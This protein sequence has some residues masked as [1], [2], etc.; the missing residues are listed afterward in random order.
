VCHCSNQM[1]QADPKAQCRETQD[2]SRSLAF[3]SLVF[4]PEVAMAPS[5]ALASEDSS[6]CSE[7]APSP[8]PVEDDS[9][10][11]FTSSSSSGAS[12]GL[13]SSTGGVSGAGRG[14]H[15]TKFGSYLSCEST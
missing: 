4:L 11:S 6:S 13:S 10:P 15:G 12:S 14:L 5:P 2:H 7:C 9:S 8:L 3:A 1:K